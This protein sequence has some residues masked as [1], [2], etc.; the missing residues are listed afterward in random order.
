MAVHAIERHIGARVLGV[1]LVHEGTADVEQI[2]RGNGDSFR[3]SISTETSSYGAAIIDLLVTFAKQH[4]EYS[5][6]NRS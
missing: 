1:D 5:V 6:A 3:R 4:P 2:A